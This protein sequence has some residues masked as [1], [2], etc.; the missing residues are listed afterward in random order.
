M[1]H[2]PERRGRRDHSGQRGGAAARLSGAQS[3][4]AAGASVSSAGRRRHSGAPLSPLPIVPRAPTAFPSVAGR[5]GSVPPAR[6]S[7]PPPPRRCGRWQSPPPR[8][9]KSGDSGRQARAAEPRPAL[10]PSNLLA[11]GRRHRQLPWAGGP[12]R[13][14]S[15]LPSSP[16]SPAPSPCRVAGSGVRS[17]E[18]HRRADSGKLAMFAVGLLYCS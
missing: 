8:E 1:R 4:R 9:A 17:A 15:T 11:G 12:R 6:P 16:S 10:H 14:R 13:P 5:G 2:D 18:E 7:P 3:R